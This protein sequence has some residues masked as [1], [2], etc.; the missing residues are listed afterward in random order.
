MSDAP[1]GQGRRKS[2][3]MQIRINVRL[4]DD[5]HQ[6]LIEMAGEE[7]RSVAQLARIIIK[8]AILDWRAK[9]PPA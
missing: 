7:E 4:D 9:R 8:R 5:I 6:G 1:A 3:R 2:V